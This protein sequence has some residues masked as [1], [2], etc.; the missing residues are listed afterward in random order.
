MNRDEIKKAIAI[1]YPAVLLDRILSRESRRQCA[2]AL[3]AA[4]VVLALLCL[5]AFG[6]KNIT[7]VSPAIL[8]WVHLL[9]DLGP[10]IIGFFL[11][12][13]GVRLAA[14]AFESFYN[15]YYFT[16]LVTSLSE[17]GLSDNKPAV[18]F[19]AASALQ[20]IFSYGDLTAGF[21][22]SKLGRRTLLR[23]GVGGEFLAKF[24]SG[25]VGA[26]DPALCAFP[27]K[28]GA[29]PTGLG[30]VALAVASLDREFTSAL[31]AR[32]VSAKDL[33]GA[34][35]WVER[36]EI[37][38]RR[39]SRFWG[40]EALG[41]IPGI[42]KNWSYGGAYALEKFAHDVTSR[43]IT[44]EDSVSH[45][46]DIEELE[47][48]LARSGEANALL[49]AEEGGGAL[50][51]I[52][53]LGSKI[54]D[55]S[56]LPPLE[57]KRIFFF[58]ANSFIAAVKTKAKF[59]AELISI[60]SQSVAAGNVILVIADLPN[61]A[62]SAGS[63]GSD[64]LALMDPYLASPDFQVIA[65]A[66]PGAFHQML[67]GDSKVLHRFEKILVKEHDLAATMRILEDRALVEESRSGVFFTYQSLAAV[68][69]ST[70]RYFTEGVLSDKAVH[71]LAEL[72]PA[73]KTRGKDF[74]TRSD[75]LALIET[76]TG[77]K[78]GAVTGDERDALLHL[79]ETLH[80]RIVGQDEAIRAISGALRRSRSDIE[81]PDRPMG[82][83]LF[84]GP[85]GVGKTETTKALAAVFFGKED[86]IIRLD[87]SEYQTN[88]AL[89]RLIGSFEGGKP[90]VLASK[91]PT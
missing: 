79:E 23:A 91:L 90:G 48:V 5:G 24:F 49:V 26:A 80:R 69:L 65:V 41:R 54:S 44:A 53:G 29:E 38:F 22:R 82:S 39:R 75:V 52:F 60:L 3:D 72:V 12:V 59:E 86:S 37:F 55:G 84:L 61:F 7:F 58:D 67:E 13:S 1:F 62:D 76:K 45:R 25:R 46:A 56:V 57:H 6:G 2:K 11:M 85:T 4:L 74:I 71:L 88:D 47:A 10:G 15:S 21:V 51:V 63:L 70:K 18:T 16:G 73:A 34:A 20:E 8:P 64:V 77:I 9:R 83:F 50:D 81:N 30:D 31:S 68:A 19:E 40:K 78:T 87:M 35:E 28:P 89:K 66:N 36:T 27:K 42:G 32:D 33:A 14:L 17:E 43:Q